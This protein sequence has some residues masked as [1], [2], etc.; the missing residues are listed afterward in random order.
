MQVRTPAWSITAHPLQWRG[1]WREGTRELPEETAVALT[2][3]RV[4]HAVMMATPADFHDF[5]VG[6]SLSE[7]VIGQP[8]DIEDFAVVPVQGGVELRMWI[9]TPLM[10]ALETRRRR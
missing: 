3:N 1:A 8:S 7:G 2:Y 5:A 10:A 6:F 4:T 9:P